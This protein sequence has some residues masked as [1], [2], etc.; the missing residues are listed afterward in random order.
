[1][2]ASSAVTC[3]LWPMWTARLA[4]WAALALVALLAF[5][6]PQPAWAQSQTPTV[7]DLIESIKQ[8]KEMALQPRPAPASLGQKGAPAAPPPRPDLSSAAPSAAPLVWSVTGLNQQFTA[9]L[10]HERKVYTVASD[11]LPYTLGGWRVHQIHEQ[12]VL[13]SRESRWLRLPVP[14]AGN[15]AYPFVQAFA[16]P[17]SE[18]PPPAVPAPTA[19]EGLTPAQ[20]LAARLPLA[21]FRGE[22]R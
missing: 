7:S 6:A 1:M 3:G 15:T 13:V 19:T 9:V 22:S 10:V 5:M 11:S 2:H 12:A 14:E 17:V 18:S 16:P 8:Q 20:A 21:P 4:A